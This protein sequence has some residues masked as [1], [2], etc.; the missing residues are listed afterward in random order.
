[1]YDIICIGNIS[2]DLYFKGDS[3]TKTNERF[4]LAIGGKYF[5]DFFQIDIGGGAAN[6]ASG[7]SKFDYRVAVFAKIGNNSFKQIILNKLQEKKISSELCD[8]VENY[9]KISAILLTNKGERTIINYET[10]SHLYRQF[11]LNEKLKVSKNI[12]IGPLP[13]VP[14][15][16]KKKMISF[17]KGDNVLTIV[18]LAANDCDQD[19]SELNEIFQSLDILIVNA[20]EFSQLI[21]IPYKQIIFKNNNLFNISTL[22]NKIVV[23]TDA[24][25]G[26]YGYYDNKIVYQSAIKPEKIIDTT[27][28]GDGYTAGF[29]AEYL[30][31]KDVEKAMQS[32][33]KYAVIVLGK[34]GA[35]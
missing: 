12:Y 20:H 22:K 23:V 32:G 33:A 18:N 13:H 34:I 16:E 24:E 31:T 15:S 4:E 17:F 10:P 7:L 8:F 28:A 1:M 35:N 21:K 9:Y 30:K 19:A 14:L 2:V 27:G 3:L 5:S 11:L 26:S 25:K 29:I 6:A